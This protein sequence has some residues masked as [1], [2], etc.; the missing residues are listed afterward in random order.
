M[1]PVLLQH[2]H[3]YLPL[4]ETEEKA[5]VQHFKVLQLK[6]KSVIFDAGQVCKGNYFVAKGCLRMYFFDEKGIEHTTQF[7][8]ENWW[9]SDYTSLALHKNSDFFLQ[10]VEDST[11]LVLE[12]AVEDAL[13]EQVPKLERYF[14]L[15]LQR[16]YGASQQLVK[17][18]HTLSKEAHYR[19]FSKSFPD[20]VQRIPQYMLASFLR[21]TPEFLS[22]IRAKKDKPIS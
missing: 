15:L 2:I 4:N 20:F 5:I 19:H 1:Y 13:F 18:N 11:V 22:K 7:A 9:I 6:K 17:Y 16:A 10:A 21:F 3:Q 14:R 8:I 12:R